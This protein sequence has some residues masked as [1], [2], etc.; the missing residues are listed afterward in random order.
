RNGTARRGARVRVPW[1]RRSGGRDRSVVPERR[2]AARFREA[3]LSGH[4][5]QRGVAARRADPA[6]RL[7][8]RTRALALPD[9]R[10]DRRAGARAT[11]L[12]CGLSPCGEE[13][14]DALDSDLDVVQLT[15]E[16]ALQTG[17]IVRA[18]AEDPLAVVDPHQEP[19]RGV[20]RDAGP[21]DGAPEERTAGN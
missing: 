18:V 2:V 15:C 7:P 1:A 21:E 16:R 12:R 10:P 4:R 19:A 14:R 11:A 3:R 9:R 6:L 13:S 5:D 20:V 8:A 17:G